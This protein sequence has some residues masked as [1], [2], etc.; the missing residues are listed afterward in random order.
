MSANQTRQPRP[1]KDNP[2]ARIDAAM[3]AGRHG[4]AL[5]MAKTLLRARPRDAGAWNVLG[6]A[7]RVS[8]RPTTAVAAY[9]RSL[10]L[11]PDQ[12]G[13]LTNLGNA[14]RDLQR[15]DEA[16]ASHRAAIERAPN[17]ASQWANLGVA[18]RDS[19]RYAEAIEA[20]DRSIELDPGNARTRVDRGQVLL[21]L[22]R[23]AEGWEDFEW[24][25]RMPDFQPPALT[26][27]LWDGS[28]QPGRT[29]LLWP[30]QGFG[31]T[32][33]CARFIAPA[34][35]RVGR[36]IVV[37]R[38]ELTRLFETMPGVDKIVPY[39]PMPPHD[40]HA[41][42]MGLCKFFVPALDR[43]PVPVRFAVPQAASERLRT[44]IG[45]SDGTFRVGIVWSGSLIFKG[46][47]LRATEFER[48]LGLSA[49]PRVRLYSLQKGP[50]A[51]D[52]RESGAAALVT[53]LAPY[54]DDFA[55]TA[56]A[57]EQ[58]D[59]V[60]MTDPSVAH[61]AGSLGTPVW[62]LLPRMPYWLTGRVTTPRRGIPRCACS[63]RPIIATGMA[64]SA[65]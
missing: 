35:E 37:C 64:C 28:P 31:D 38:P 60:V 49:V 18:L 9:T 24:R 17:A 3:S 62:N 52:L 42:L 36:V 47:A 43:I 48:F 5:A 53:D 1:A 10:D 8:G 59:L 11:V 41:P 12:P 34:R 44:V 14:W 13:V 45:P 6:V 51:K 56:A 57:L 20:Y 7:L 27:P 19:A 63:G 15:F 55:D 22:G 16:I 2:V 32:M 21:M 61:L 25:W 4:E 30:Q 40:L 65:A 46:N 23:Y 26:A 39:G 29:L 33:L 50:R 58:L 54:L